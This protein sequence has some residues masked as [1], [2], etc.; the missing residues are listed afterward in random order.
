MFVSDR[1]APTVDTQLR[2]LIPA[3]LAVAVAATAMLGPLRQFLQPSVYACDRCAART[4]IIAAVPANEP[5]AADNALVTALVDEHPTL[6][7]AP[8]LLDSTGNPITAPWV[9]L[10]RYSTA[11]PDNP[12]WASTL[13]NQLINFGHYRQWAAQGG[14]A[15]LRRTP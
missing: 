3:A 12:A 4:A 13:E 1:A 14:Y 2:R 8:G 7:A 5:V 10:D 9:P 15:L 6:L 11:R